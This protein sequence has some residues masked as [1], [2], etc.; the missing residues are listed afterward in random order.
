MVKTL[1]LIIQYIFVFADWSDRTMATNRKHNK[2]P[3]Q[4]KLVMRPTA[5]HQPSTHES[6]FEKTRA[7]TYDIACKMSKKSRHWL[8][9]F[10]KI[11]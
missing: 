3:I 1:K 7:E 6:G 4:G 9:Y 2:N 5:D 11:L 10:M 8:G